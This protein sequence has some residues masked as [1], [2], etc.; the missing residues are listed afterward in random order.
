MLIST[1]QSILNSSNCSSWVPFTYHL[2][3][4]ISYLESYIAF[5]CHVSF[6]SFRSGMVLPPLFYMTLTFW[7]I[8]GQLFCIMSLNIDFLM[9]P[10]NQI[11]DQHFGRNT[12]EVICS[13][14]S[15]MW[16]KYLMLTSPPGATLVMLILVM[17][18]W[19]F[20]LRWRL[21]GFSTI[22]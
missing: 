12:M 11:E 20:W 21:P 10:H 15:I 18:T 16:P 2:S 17:L 7:G 19:G 14:H 22:K 3:K 8:I 9:S 13:S 1:A 6:I 5:G 4:P